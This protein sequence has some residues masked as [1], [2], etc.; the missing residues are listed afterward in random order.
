M[1]TDYYK[2]EGFISREHLKSTDNDVPTVKYV[3][4]FNGGDILKIACTQ[5][6]LSSYQQKKLVDSWC[7]FLPTCEASDI[8]FY[9]RVNQK[10][11]DAACKAINL[12][13]LFIKWASN[14]I[15][16]YDS[17]NKARGITR[18]Y[19]GSVTQV[20]DLTAISSL[21]NLEWLE[22]HEHKILRDLSPLSNLKNL[23]G[24]RMSGGLFGTQKINSLKPLTRLTK[25]RRLY[26]SNLVAL[27]GDLSP[28][29]NLY[30][31][32]YLDLAN[33]YS[34]EELIKLAISI[35]DCDHGINAFRD[36]HIKCQK[37]DKGFVLEVMDKRK[38][39]L[40]TV[41]DE[42]KCQKI[43][44]RYQNKYRECLKK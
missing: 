16:T 29:T 37:C 32:E 39:F 25:L 38:K 35:P 17:L 36:K 1:N 33:R 13:S 34:T 19:L 18:L 4:E 28:L 6:A 41:C 12:N 22:I 5:T 27:D 14:G 10:L 8:R 40:C 30:Q 11:F 21:S 43:K 15:S 7:E 9:S 42:N 3:D 2:T 44:K 26:L 20:D 23:I 24:I 31:L